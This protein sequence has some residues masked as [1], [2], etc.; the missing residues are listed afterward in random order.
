VKPKMRTNPLTQ[1]LD[2]IIPRTCVQCGGPVEETAYDYVCARCVQDL[3]IV[4]PPFCDTCGFPFFGVVEKV[5]ACPRC[6]EM[7]PR[8]DAGRTVFLHRGVGSVFV[9][10]LKY[11]QAMYLLSDIEKC[12]VQ[13]P[14]LQ[15]YLEGSVLVPVP[16][17]PRK[18][19]ER[20]FNQS[21]ALAECFA[22][23]GGGL[24]VVDGL[25]RRIDTE[26]QTSLDRIHRQSNVKNA[27]AI[28]P[29]AAFNRS[30]RYILID[31]VFTTGATL[32]ACSAQLRKAG[33]EHLDV[34]TLAHG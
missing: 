13:S 22:R 9:R 3:Y 25:V 31:D 11:R 5:P 30:Q 21:T 18:R 19:R 29:K 32:N 7:A 12:C 24:E 10:E 8:F 14:G 15:R 28:A 4:R 2:L 27:F 33:V 6:R 26:S 20:G 17:H 23:V 16:L 1:V 34:L